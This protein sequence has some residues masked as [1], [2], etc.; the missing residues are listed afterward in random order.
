MYIYN[1]KKTRSLARS[2]VINTLNQ[3]VIGN[4]W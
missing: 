4:L 2:T 3:E 1:F